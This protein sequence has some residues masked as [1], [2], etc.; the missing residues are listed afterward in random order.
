MWAQ[1]HGYAVERPRT[2][3][4]MFGHSRVLSGEFKDPKRADDCLRLLTVKAANR[5]RRESYTAAAMSVSF[6]DQD[7]RRWSYET[8]FA[9]CRDDHSLLGQ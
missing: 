4:R 3:R 8:Q 5:L 7:K 2:T 1:L 6:K 9:P